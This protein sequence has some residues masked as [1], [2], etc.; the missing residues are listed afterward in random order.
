MDD[1]TRYTWLYP[2]KFKS[3]VLE[4]F[5]NF[6]RRV[7]RQ[8]NLK[9][10]NFQSDW[11]RE[12]QPMSKYLK[13]HGIHHRLSCPHTPTQNGTLERKHR[14]V[15]VT[16]LSL[17]KQASMPHKFWEEAVCTT[18][19]LINRIPTPLL[20][21]KSPYSLLFTPESDY[22]FLQNFG[23]TCYPCLHHYSASKLDSRSERCV[24]IGY[25]AY[26]HGYRCLSMTFGRI[27]ISRDVIFT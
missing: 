18:I 17:V 19:Y 27:Y 20:D 3:D 11:G 13:D 15:I 4:T 8:F 7:E 16:S 9:I 10:Q 23:C 5:V 21:Y 22:K 1:F 26:H 25:S 2:L 14:H 24:A 6:H 12:F